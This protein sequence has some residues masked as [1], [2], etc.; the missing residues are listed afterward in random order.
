M[1]K[2][3]KF[4][5]DANGTIALAPCEMEIRITPLADV[6]EDVTPLDL[7]G[8]HHT[9]LDAERGALSLLIGVE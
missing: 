2:V 7:D 3:F 1:N 6:I 4:T 9:M 8:V 5:P